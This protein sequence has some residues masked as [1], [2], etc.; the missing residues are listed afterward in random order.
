MSRVAL[1]TGG[2]DGIG[3]AVCE[4]LLAEGVHVVCLSRRPEAALEWGGERDEPGHGNFHYVSGDAADAGDLQRM[5]DE[6]MSRYG[7]VDIL[8]NNAGQN[9]RTDIEHVDD[10]E[11]IGGFAVKPMGLIR[12][13]RIVRPIMTAQGTGRVVNIAGQRGI[14]PGD[15]PALASAFNAAVL[16]LTKSMARSV[17]SLGITVNAVSPGTTATSRTAE[18]VAINAKAWGVSE[19]EATQRMVAEIP[20]GRFVTVEEVAAAV[21]FLGSADASGITGANLRVDGGRSQSI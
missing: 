2:A 12:A 19:Q 6:A 16:N 14:E 9:P 18:T 3:R 8:V 7:R 4:R 17:A 21:A 13:W 20:L 5:V 1:V 11:W 15:R 10:D